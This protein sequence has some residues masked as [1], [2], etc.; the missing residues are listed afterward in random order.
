MER[1]TLNNTDLQVSKLCFGTMT[2]GGQTPE[3]ASI[4]LIDAALADGLN[5]FDT[6]DMYNEGRAEEIL[7]KALSGKRA[8]VVLASKVYYPLHQD[9][10][11]GL[12]A[13]R[14]REKLEGSLKR[15]NTDYL[16]IYYLHQPDRETSLNE[17][18][19][20]LDTFKKEG[21]IR[22]YGVS[23]FAAWQIAEMF[24]VA[25]RLGVDRPVVTQN[26]YNALTRGIEA[27]LMPF[28]QENQLPIHAYNPLAG[29]LLTGK[30]SKT[31]VDMKGRLMTDEKYNK[32][33]M[34]LRSLAATKELIDVAR[35]VGRHIVELM[36]LWV[37]QDPR[38][39]SMI[40]GVSNLSQYRQNMAYLRSEPLSVSAMEKVSAV[41]EAHYDRGFDYFR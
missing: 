1:Y 19:E 16:D 36:L 20:A 21:K 18:L 17:T 6:A 41:G 30:Y 23:N 35:Q 25:D 11:R 38:I 7:G 4:E 37:Y 31:G 40:I 13:S 5:F 8:D 3:K 14:M 22:Y 33:Y 32:R 27:E 28:C 9:D 12:S 29:G 34:S 10:S 15:L 24:S 2:F 39:A 26:V